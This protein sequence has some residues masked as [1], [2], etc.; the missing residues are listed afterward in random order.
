MVR[1]ESKKVGR[2]QLV[3]SLR[4]VL[5]NLESIQSS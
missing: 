1:D 2:G 3:K 4:A 5:R